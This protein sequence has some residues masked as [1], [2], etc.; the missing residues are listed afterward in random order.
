MRGRFAWDRARRL[1]RVASAALPL[2]AAI[3]LITVTAQAQDLPTVPDDPTS[4]IPD[5]GSGVSDPSDPGSLDEAYDQPG[6]AVDTDVTPRAKDAEF[7]QQIAGAPFGGLDPIAPPTPFDQ[8]DRVSFDTDLFDV[9]F[10]NTRSGFAGGSRCSDPPTKDEGETDADY[11]REVEQCDRVPALYQYTHPAN[12]DPAWRLVSLPGDSLEGFVGA[13]AWIDAE[14]AVAVGGTGTYPRREPSR[15]TDPA[16][17]DPESYEQWLERDPAG[18]GRAWLYQDGRWREITDDLP[19]GTRGMTA[20]D[21]HPGSNAEVG[22]AGALGQIVEWRSGAFESLLDRSSPSAR[23][24]NHKLLEYRVREIRF[25]TGEEVHAFGVTSGC[26]AESPAMNIPRLLAYHENGAGGPRWFV[27]KLN[28]DLLDDPSELAT[29]EDTPAE[30]A[31]NRPRRVNDRQDLPDSAYS[32]TP[33]QR[34]SV[35]SA[36]CSSIVASAGGEATDGERPSVLTQ[37]YPY[38]EAG[39]SANIVAPV[40]F[41]GTPG[42]SVLDPAVGVARSHLSSARIVAADGD[43]GVSQTGPRTFSPDAVDNGG[44]GSRTPKG[45][46]YP[47]WLVGQLRS[48]ALDGLGTQALAVAT[49][50]HPALVGETVNAETAE[51]ISLAEFP[52]TRPTPAELTSGSYKPTT[53]EKVLDYPISR[54]F[55]LPSY[56]LNAIDMVGPLGESGIGWAV[57]DHGAILTLSEKKIGTGSTSEP[58]PPRL[59]G[60]RP[61]SALVDRNAYESSRPPQG[62][63][64]GPVP[65]LDALPTEKL[66]EPRLLTAGSPDPTIT[67]TEPLEATEDVA[68]IVMSRDG[69]EGWAIGPNLITANSGS[70]DATTS[71]YHFEGG[72]WSRCDPFGIKGQLPPD[73]ACAGVAGLRRFTSGM[74]GELGPVQSAKLR[75]AARVP[76]ENDSD[77][78]NDDEF[79]VVAIGTAYR[80]KTS[81]QMRAVILRYRDGRWRHED[82]ERRAAVAVGGTTTFL[83]D[84]AFAAPDDGWIRSGSTLYHFDG[85]RWIDCGVGSVNCG[86]PNGGPDDRLP[87]DQG[88]TLYGMAAAGDRIF[89]FGTRNVGGFATS[90]LH[91]PLVLVHRAGEP[92]WR[93]DSA[94]GGLDP[95]F[96]REGAGIA[97]GGIA[98]DAQQGVVRSLSISEGPDGVEGWAIGSFGGITAELP[99]TNLLRYRNGPGWEPFRDTGAARDYLR[100]ELSLPRSLQ[101]TLPSAGPGAQSL[102]AQPR[103]GRILTF[104]ATRGRWEHL[105]EAQVPDSRNVQA[106][107]PDNQ[108]GAW[109]AVRNTQDVFW[110][111]P[112]SSVWFLHYTDRAPAEVFDETAHP[113]RSAGARITGLAGGPDGTVWASTNSNLL[114]RYDRLLGWETVRVQGWDPGRVVTRASEANAI[115]VGPTG[116][117]LV[118]GRGGRIADLSPGGVRLDSA[119]G[120]A[121]DLAAP[122]A[123][124]GTGRDLRA[125]AIAPDGSALVGGDRLALLWRPAG[126]DF[127]AIERPDAPA[128]STITAIS[129]PRSGEAW[130]TTT[131]G[132]VFHGRMDGPGNW[133]WDGGENRT[134][135]GELLSLD[136]F[137]NPLPLR[138]VAINGDGE[139]YAVGDH[140]LILRRTGDGDQP[141]RRLDTPFLDH[142]TSIALPAGTGEGALIGGRN[143]LILTGSGDRFSVAR[144]ADYSSGL[145]GDLTGPVVGLAMLPGAEAGEV[146]AWAAVQ[147][148][149][150]GTNRVLRYSSDSDDPLLNPERRAPGLPDVPGGADGELSFAAFG[151]TECHAPTSKFC[152]ERQA[153]R[154]EY[155]VLARTIAD[156]LERGARGGELGFGLFTGDSVDSASLPASDLPDQQSST[157]GSG[158]ILASGPI[159]LRRWREQ[160]VED[161]AD[162]GVPLL[163]S[164]G[165]QDLSE[166]FVCDVDGN[167]YSSKEHAK[168]GDNLT[169]RQAMASAPGPWGS[170]DTPRANGL[171]FE[172]V[173]GADDQSTK[174]E[175]VEVDPDGDGAAPGVT[176]PTGGARTHY[177]AEIARDGERVARLVVLDNSLRSLATSDPAQQPR[178]GAGGQLAWLDRMLCVEGDTPTGGGSCTR[179]PGQ[180]AIVMLNTPTYTY[181]PGAITDTATDGALV[182]QTLLE[183]NATV[184]VSGRLGWNGLYYTL[185][186]GLHTPCPGGSHPLGPPQGA[187]P[188]CAPAELGEDPA[189]PVTD[190]QQQLL[191]G[192]GDAGGALPTVVASGGGGKF[193]PDGQATG[194]AAEGFWHGYSLVRLVPGQGSDFSAP[195]VV[196][197]QRPVLDWISIEGNQRVVRAGKKLELRGI[198][199]EPIGVS[200]GSGGPMVTRFDEI[201]SPAITHRYELLEADPDRPWLPK[202]DQGSSDDAT[203]VRSAASAR[204]GEADPCG[205]YLCL[206]PKV[207]TVDEQTGQVRAGNGQYPRTFAVA[208]LSVG[209]MSATYPLVFEPR[210]S[211][212]APAPPPPVPVAVP[213]PPPPPAAASP[214]SP[215]VNLPAAPVLPVLTAQALAAPPVPPSPPTF[216]SQAPLDLNLSPAALDVSP[217]T[218][219]SQPPTPPVNPAP[220]S[221]ARREARQRQAAAQK[222]GAD[223]DQEGSEAQEGG[224]DLAQSSDTVPGSSGMSRHEFTVAAH[225]DQP[226][227]W[228][229]DGLLGGGLGIAALILALGVNKARPTPRRREPELP[230]PAWARNR[231]R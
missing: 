134:E 65:A 221:G 227:A 145:R 164:I 110:G 222:S 57:G 74:P 177:A 212:K 64:V 179:E 182:E 81:D 119:A 143:G 50:L 102:I 18:S 190:L 167:C 48:T 16:T 230:A 45:D 218:A 47:D 108:G 54:Y 26:C 100:S 155:E 62:G 88:V 68:E 107:A 10:R 142:L 228:V 183:R 27:H 34:P 106:I 139:G 156:E 144:A 203:E 5:L 90:A 229:R 214:T 17:G 198:G 60:S 178:E 184:A 114:A 194:S 15:E 195:G 3:T 172:P 213:A 120:R 176:V 103:T 83:N 137:G 79:E 189:E 140:G 94:D 111:L 121:C 29:G 207:G 136:L 197:E 165:S 112:S 96:G 49:H 109:I 162:G 201:S 126:G 125:A 223:S 93:A 163:G 226:S 148:R 132:A 82:P 122:S 35:S 171:S 46:A 211:F 138:A 193:G 131:E 185:A 40:P 99:E 98:T 199:R 217:P 85:E 77:P 123:P 58:E 169:W 8:S 21:F 7:W 210:S 135:K 160:V 2:A 78:S 61:P 53:Q 180:A 43:I 87:A 152:S 36:Y 151:K 91:Y 37:R 181:G 157:R 225:R 75:A 86:D 187:L 30:E 69:S 12:A 4:A 80:E 14:R 130:L 149:G 20:L 41:F 104:N 59:G 205:P 97:G 186:P 13:I 23:L 175:N 67:P 63:E 188:E 173:P 158:G 154:S 33:P 216:A 22:A 28:W 146:E 153:S 124:C 51:N 1:L 161:L 113:L 206:D 66:P 219:V 24:H 115:A 76:F 55:K 196:I 95:G 44:C 39:Q 52:I 133:T 200:S 116:E 215:S 11:G 38:S 72:T 168:A 105:T 129:M 204:L 89:A 231:R 220:P 31:L 150:S 170:E 73:P 117:G 101:A 141:W 92:G 159:K 25:V 191:G 202:Q 71:L 174:A 32:M 42:T 224:G 56:A 70:A 208:Q 6:E 9:S 128:S 127:S 19:D 192:G 118:V 166:A 84:V 209:E 147:E